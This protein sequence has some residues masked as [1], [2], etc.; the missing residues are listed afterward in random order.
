MDASIAD[1]NERDRRIVVDVLTFLRAAA[2]ERGRAAEDATRRDDASTA[3]ASA[4][5]SATMRA[6][7]LRFRVRTAAVRMQPRRVRRWGGRDARGRDARARRG[8]GGANDDDDGDANDDDDDVDD[9]TSWRGTSDAETSARVRELLA[10][11][12]HAPYAHE[13]LED[14]KRARGWSGSGS[15]M[16][17]T[18]VIRVGVDHQAIVP[19]TRD[20]TFARG[21]M[22]ARERAYL[23]WR[24]FPPESGG[25]SATR[26]GT[27]P[28]PWRV[29]TAATSVD[30]VASEQ[31]MGVVK[32]TTEPETANANDA[33]RR[34]ERDAT[35]NTNDDGE[36]KEN[37]EDSSAVKTPKPLF[38]EEEIAAARKSLE[39]ALRARGVDDASG[40]LGLATV[41]ATRA[42]EHW[43]ADEMTTFSAH[44]TKYAD[45]LI[46]C[47]AKLPKK[48][49][50]DVVS[51][52]YNVWQVGCGNLGRVDVE[53]AEDAAPRERARRGP[54]PKHTS[55]EIQREKDGR[56]I[57]SFL[58]YIRA[59]A[60]N[61]KRAML[62]VHR[63]P[64]TARVHGH[65][66]TRFRA[67]T[68]PAPGDTE[69]YLRDLERRMEAAKF[70]P[71]DLEAAAKI[72][73]EAKAELARAKARAYKA[74]L[75]AAKKA[76]RES[77]KTETSR[78]AETNDARSGEGEGSGGKNR[79]V[80]APA[81]KR[82]K[83]TAATDAAES[84]KKRGAKA[85]VK[86]TDAVRV[87]A[88]KKLHLG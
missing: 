22:D 23:G 32:T 42:R 17:R 83:K 55:E 82:A 35:A 70:T 31:A 64:T 60:V 14:S 77:E 21:T 29:K 7:L 18:G 24:M 19:E 56:T 52:Y 40:L 11:L 74:Q 1:A 62:N 38:T 27:R 20:A 8:V 58:E 44:V 37:D 73:A 86:A 4:S 78:S 43:D 67:A 76:A 71:E 59:V 34:A 50:R 84:T 61:P 41:G 16:S 33:R 85:H 87:G 3:S 10:V 6:R 69:G 68:H 88:G 39:D 30:D 72:K 79:V 25:T 12:A 46:R 49:M 66:M 65:I 53:G 47:K 15:T 54:V 9:D 80:E 57:Q 75:K 81:P 5:A 28:S 36:E 2:T 26:A 63:A 13:S 45:D 51:Y 48:T